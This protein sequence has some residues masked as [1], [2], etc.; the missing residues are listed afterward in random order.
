[1]SKK[2]RKSGAYASK[3]RKKKGSGLLVGLLVVFVILLAAAIG[4]MLYLMASGGNQDTTPTTAPQTEAPLETTQPAPSTQAPIET[5]VPTE[6]VPE[7]NG[8]LGYG[9][10]MEDMASYTGMYMEDGSDEIL[11]GILMMVVENIGEQDIQ[12]A[13]ITVDLGEEQALFTIS[14]LP[15]GAKAVLLEQNRMAYDS[16]LN[17]GTY[18]PVIDSIAYF[19]EPMDIQEDQVKVQILNG[20]VN[21]T[22]ICGQ[23]IPG[24]IAVYYKNAASDIFYGGITYRVTLE[25]GLKADEIRQIMTNHASETGSRIMFVTISE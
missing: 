18:L 23:D 22:N 9:I 14:S 24:T 16:S 19:P 13:Q 5:T 3:R 25:G 6:P 8:N 15:A 4:M 7:V 2:K 1:M 12:Y 20:A 11:S 10:F 17:Y 21:I